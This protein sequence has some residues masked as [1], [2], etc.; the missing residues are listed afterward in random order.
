MGKMWHLADERYLRADW[1]FREAE[2]LRG[3][4]ELDIHAGLDGAMPPGAAADSLRDG[5][6]LV[7]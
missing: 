5:F 2:R 6:L 1:G 7:C 3:S 4:G